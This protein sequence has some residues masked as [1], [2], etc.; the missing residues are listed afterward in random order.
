MLLE[1]W[2]AA[3]AAAV[4]EPLVAAAV[5]LADSELQLAAGA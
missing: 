5:G 3:V 2:T 4:A 1:G